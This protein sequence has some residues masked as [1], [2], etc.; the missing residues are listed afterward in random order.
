MPETT[1]GGCR[2]SG[3]LGTAGGRAAPAAALRQRV[4]LALR[5]ARLP[6]WTAALTA[7]VQGPYHTFP[8]KKILSQ[9]IFGQRFMQDL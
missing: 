6:G 1:A 4:P 7:H 8:S 9:L 3:A 2:G 5:G